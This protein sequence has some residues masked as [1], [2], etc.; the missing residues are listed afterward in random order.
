MDN[1]EFPEPYESISELEECGYSYD[2]V[3]RT[4]YN[5]CLNCGA[6]LDWEDNSQQ[7]ERNLL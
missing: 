2:H 5:E 7:S 1:D 4:G 6:E 3:I